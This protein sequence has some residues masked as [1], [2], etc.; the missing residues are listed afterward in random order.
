[1]AVNGV[2]ALLYACFWLLEAGKEE[3][4][5]HMLGRSK[6]KTDFL[7]FVLIGEQRG[8][9]LRERIYLGAGKSWSGVSMGFEYSGINYLKM[10]RLGRLLENIDF[11]WK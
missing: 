11:E 10:H 7:C 2:T 6:R 3:I 8:N 9:A 1:M 4:S 5:W